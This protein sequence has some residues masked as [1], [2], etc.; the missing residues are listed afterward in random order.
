[1]TG[2]HRIPCANP[3]GGTTQVA[4]GYHTGDRWTYLGTRMVTRHCGVEVLSGPLK[5][6]IYPHPA[7]AAEA[8][9]FYTQRPGVVCT[10]TRAGSDP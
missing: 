7:R 5:G 8:V 6:C 10:T 9:R 1:M 3:S 2:R 4:F